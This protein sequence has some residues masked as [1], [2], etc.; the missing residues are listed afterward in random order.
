MAEGLLTW[1]FHSPS[2]EMKRV[3]IQSVLDDKLQDVDHEQG[4]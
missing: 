1:L 3:G 4:T 2:R